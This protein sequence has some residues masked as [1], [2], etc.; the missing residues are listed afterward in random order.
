MFKELTDELFDLTA[1]AKGDM[2]AYFAATID[3]CSCCC[4]CR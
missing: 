1:S 3:C 2:A 4:C